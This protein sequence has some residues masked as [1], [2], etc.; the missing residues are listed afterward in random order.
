MNFTINRTGRQWLKADS[1]TAW[2]HLIVG[3]I[4]MIFLLP[5]VASFL[6][7]NTSTFAIIVTL[8]LIFIVVASAYGL[9]TIFHSYKVNR[10]VT[11]ISIDEKE[12]SFITHKILWLEQQEVKKS[13]DELKTMFSANIPA[14]KRNKEGLLI[15]IGNLEFYIIEEFYNEYET[16]KEYILK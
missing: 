11:E 3:S 10:I 5:Y 9:T 6:K 13:A 4:I 16:L 2:I 15:K 12:V 1:L 8:F 7:G 14:Y